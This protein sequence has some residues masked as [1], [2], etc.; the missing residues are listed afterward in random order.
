MCIRDR[1]LLPPPEYDYTSSD[2]SEGEDFPD[3]GYAGEQWEL[4]GTDTYDNKDVYDLWDDALPEGKGRKQS[5][6]K[7]SVYT[8]TTLII[9]PLCIL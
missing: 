8:P 5:T 4:G 9:T 3:V 1:E 6:L 2:S 7:R